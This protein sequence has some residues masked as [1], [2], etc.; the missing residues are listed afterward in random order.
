M[1][2]SEDLLSTSIEELN[3]YKHLSDQIFKF[4]LDVIPLYRI[5]KTIWDNKNNIKEYKVF[6]LTNDNKTIYNV[7]VDEYNKIIAQA[8]IIYK[9]GFFYSDKYKIYNNLYKSIFKEVEK[10]LWNYKLA[11]STYYTY[12]L[13]KDIDRFFEIYNIDKDK[14]S[15]YF[16]YHINFV[17]PWVYYKPNK[18]ILPKLNKQLILS[19]EISLH[20][21]IIKIEDYEK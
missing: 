20:P 15:F 14:F 5:N 8:K 11:I 2:C 7:Y 1:R 3:Y 4:E 19:K 17:Y 18:L 12:L 13:Y 10:N 9:D 21:N 16:N 6:D